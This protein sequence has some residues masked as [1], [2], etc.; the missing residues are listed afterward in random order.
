MKLTEELIPSPLGSNL[1]ALGSLG[2]GF[3]KGTASTWA[4]LM[5]LVA[6]TVGAGIMSLPSAIAEVGWV[7]GFLLLVMATAVSMLCC[8]L[9]A[10]S[11]VMAPQCESSEELAHAAYGPRME[12]LVLI[13][14]NCDLFATCVVLLVASRDACLNV[15]HTLSGSQWLIVVGVLCGFL[16]LPKDMSGLS[17]ASSFGV[18][19][20]FVFVL[21]YVV[22]AFEAVGEPGGQDMAN[23][24]LPS[25]A[26][27]ASNIGFSYSCAIL[28]PTMSK[29]MAKPKE[30]PLVVYSAHGMVFSLYCM[31]AYAGYTCYGD[32]LQDADKK[33]I[34]VMVNETARFIAGCSIL[35]TIVVGYPCFLNP[36]AVAVE[37]WIQA[38]EEREMPTRVAV[39]L[40]IASASLFSALVL[41][42]FYEVVS[43]TGAVT[44][45]SMCVLFPILFFCRLLR[46]K[47]PMGI[48]KRYYLLMG[49][50]FVACCYGLN[51][52]AVGVYFSVQDLADAVRAKYMMN[53]SGFES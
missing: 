4:T 11:I 10:R 14:N 42:F 1:E 20:L 44:A 46:L 3:T 6:A 50:I 26:S 51:I 5:N 35:V 53:V 22:D 21:T 34:N 9:V 18:A 16:S 29:D 24:A 43:V 31:V 19:T 30:L 49:P 15:S 17:A 37:K 38:P 47:N 12:R 13:V 2:F 23:W 36:I 8:I 40:S 39:R 25:L 28:I 48:P 33:G 7:P 45:N 41:P 52:M 27:S 32:S